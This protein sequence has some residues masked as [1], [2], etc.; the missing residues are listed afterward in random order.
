MNGKDPISDS[1]NHMLTWPMHWKQIRYYLS[2]IF[3]DKY[4]LVKANLI[5]LAYSLDNPGQSHNFLQ[6]LLCK[7]EISGAYSKD[8]NL[9]FGQSVVGS[10]P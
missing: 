10:R 9:K 8:N 6:Y 1:V 2:A 7:I 5:L 4:S 3:V